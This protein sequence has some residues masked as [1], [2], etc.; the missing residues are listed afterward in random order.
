MSNK[1][2]KCLFVVIV[3]TLLLSFHHNLLVQHI[4]FS[5]KGVR[6][7]K[8]LPC[9]KAGFFHFA[10]KSSVHNAKLTLTVQAG[11]EHQ[12]LLM[13]VMQ[14]G[15]FECFIHHETMLLV[16]TT[17][18]LIY[19]FFSSNCILMDVVSPLAPCSGSEYT[20]TEIICMSCN[21]QWLP[22]GCSSV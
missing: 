9:L 14:Y 6:C 3:I 7:R 4:D 19:T 21:Y 20:Y 18:S 13:T 10:I 5:P 11:C 12:H 15:R 22:L 8:C 2:H 16:A 1:C 17:S